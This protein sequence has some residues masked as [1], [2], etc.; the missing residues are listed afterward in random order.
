M[1][2]YDGVPD[3]ALKASMDRKEAIKAALRRKG[4]GVTY[5]PVE[6]MYGA[7]KLSN[8]REIACA[9]SVEELSCVVT[10]KSYPS[11]A[12]SV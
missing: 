4:I 8:Y 12:R 9:S 7:Y 3:S 11:V 10:R 5:F 2:M 6:G 1:R